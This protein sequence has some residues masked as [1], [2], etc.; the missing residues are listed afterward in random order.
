M[1][2]KNIKTVDVFNYLKEIINFFFP[3]QIVITIF[4][5]IPVVFIG[6]TDVIHFDDPTAL[7]WGNFSLE[8]HKDFITYVEY[9]KEIL[10]IFLDLITDQGFGIQGEYDLP[11]IL[12]YMKSQYEV[13]IDP[14]KLLE[15]LKIITMNID[16]FNQWLSTCNRRT[17]NAEEI[18]AFIEACRSLDSSSSSSSDSS[19]TSSGPDEDN[20]EFEN[21]FT[22]L[23]YILLALVFGGT[24][25]Y[26][27]KKIV[28]WFSRPA[29]APAPVPA[30]KEESTVSELHNHYEF[31]F[32]VEIEFH[33][34][35]IVVVI[36]IFFLLMFLI[37]KKFRNKKKKKNSVS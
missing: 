37:I 11:T 17:Y 7:N 3:K 6:I 21:A 15:L 33:F 9:L 34:V 2:K 10:C 30:P 19:S 8:D 13:T 29:P 5:I 32:Y 28:G 35:H 22:T 4:A 12:R 14:N 18:R 31:D 36:I 20:D 27:F 26:L 23:C 24:L 1:E 25:A 16:L